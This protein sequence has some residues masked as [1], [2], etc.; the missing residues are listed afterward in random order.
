[1]V[2]GNRAREPDLVIRNGKPAAVILGID[3]YEELLERAADVTDLKTLRAMRKKP[4]G[5]TK[6]SQFLQKRRARV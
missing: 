5:F 1:M 4:L 3:E 6:L 2:T